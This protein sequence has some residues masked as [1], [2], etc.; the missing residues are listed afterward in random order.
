MFNQTEADEQAWL[1]KVINKLEEACET[2]DENVAK[3]AKELQEQKSYLYENKTGMAAAEKAAVKQTVNMQAISGEA[4][5][6]CKKRGVPQT[7]R[8]LSNCSS[9]AVMH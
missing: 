4:A 6:A 8:H 2:A 5:V 1:A 9:P 3:T 7:S